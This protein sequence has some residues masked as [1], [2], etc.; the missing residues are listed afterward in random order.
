MRDQG[1]SMA[2]LWFYHLE[3]ANVDEVLPELLGKLMERDGRA[4][5]CSGKDTQLD[6]LD[7]HL[8][9]FRDDSFLPHG[10]ADS[11]QVEDQPIVLSR[12]PGNPNKADMLFC[13]D[14]VDPGDVT[15]W[16]RVVVMFEGSD[17]ASMACARALWTNHKKSEI[18]ISYWRQNDAGRWHREA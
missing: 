8:W 9:T 6:H 2:E 11:T 10:R 5:V 14:G 15:A 13:L 12:T 4:V 7:S 18:P 16:Q 1:R 17:E 3:R